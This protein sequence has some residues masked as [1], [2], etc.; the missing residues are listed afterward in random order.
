M[1]L[2]GGGRRADSRA[3]LSTGP[4]STSS[5]AASLPKQLPRL[6]AI[7]RI[8]SLIGRPTEP[9]IRRKLPG[10]RAGPARTLPER[11][12]V[13]ALGRRDALL[14][15]AREVRAQRIA[16]EL[17][18]LDLPARIVHDQR[19]DGDL[20]RLGGGEADEPGV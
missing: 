13:A 1:S 9:R 15:L 12:R 2:T 20:G 16:R 6:V 8:V 3:S 18:C 17:R 11:R 5:S 10:L 14:A 4:S 7:R 19:A